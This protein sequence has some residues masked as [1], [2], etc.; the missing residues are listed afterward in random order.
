M[1]NYNESKI[2]KICCRDTSIENIYVGSTINF[3]RRKSEHKKVCNNTNSKE[4]NKKAYQFIRDNGG[5]ENWDM[6]LL[7][8]V[9]VNNRLELHKKEREFIEL[10]KPSLNMIIPTRTQKEYKEDNK[11]T[12]KERMKEYKV[13]YYEKN[14]KTLKE[15]QEEYYEN[16]KETLKEKRK[17]Y[18]ENNKETLKEKGKVKI[19]CECGSVVRKCSIARHRKTK[20]HIA[21]IQGDL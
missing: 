6:I 15:Y 8:G 20:K 11:E 5:W 2:Y 12:I 16:N 7:E 10:L 14:K 19:T 4:Y 17:E 21:F 3:N 9:E 18:L 13:G 1:P